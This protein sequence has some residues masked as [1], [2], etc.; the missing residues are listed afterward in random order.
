MN[1]QRHRA[2]S[3]ARR[4]LVLSSL[5]LLLPANLAFAS[6]LV[7]EGGETLS[8]QQLSSL[9]VQ[10][11][12]TDD[13]A[14]ITQT[15]VY[16]ATPSEQGA[17]E[18]T[19]HL[20][21]AAGTTVSA[22]RVSD[23]AQTFEVLDA[24][25]ADSL[26]RHL[27][28]GLRESGPMRGLGSEMLVVEPFQHEP[29]LGSP[30]ITL[31]LE[32]PLQ[33]RGTLQGVSL[34]VDWCHATVNDVSISV[35]AET[36]APLRALYGPYTSL[37]VTRDGLHRATASHWSYGLA[38][39]LPIELLL[40]SGEEPIR[41][42]LLPFRYSPD[43]DSGYVMALLTADSEPPAVD[44]VPRDIAVVLD[45]S[46]SMDGEKIQQGRAALNG[47]LDGLSPADRV[48]LF[49]FNGSVDSFRN[50]VTEADADTIAAGKAFVSDIIADGETN[51][52][53]AL[54]AAF[55]ALP[56][57]SGHPRYIVFITD[58]IPTAGETDVE[59]ILANARKHESKTRIFTFGVGLDVNTVLL[60]QLAADSGGDALY[61]WPGQSVATAVATFFD[62]I[63]APL[64][65]DPVLNLSAFGVTDLQPTVLQ[66][67][68]AGQTALVVGRY[69]TPGLGTF[70]LDGHDGTS[71]VSHVFEVTLPNHEVETGYVPRVWATRRIG[72]M[73]QTVKLGRGV[74]GVVE[75]AVRLADRWGIET[76][77]TSWTVDED[78]DTSMEYS[79]VPQD[80]SG[81][82]AVGTSSSIDSYTKE[83]GYNGAGALASVR[84]FRDRTLA[85]REGW[86]ADTSVPDGQEFHH[87]HF[88]SAAYFDLAEQ[89]ADAGIGGFF[90][91]GR[92]L[93]FELMGAHIA[94]TDAADAAHPDAAPETEGAVAAQETP[95]GATETALVWSGIETA[96]VPGH[97]TAGCSGSRGLPLGSLAGVLVLMALGV[98]RRR[99]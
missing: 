9:S 35:T 83:D 80:S 76:D 32:V 74:G 31:K 65:A 1:S 70:S 42:D 82:A 2:W 67:V 23:A 84:F 49:T 62:Q 14:T 29:H 94:V 55:N 39:E 5:A 78:G 96:P 43:P 22:V 13:G 36:T 53:A 33:Q 85:L 68:F 95:M 3:A 11:T 46:G 47:V 40:S 8:L 61:V 86:Y 89:L 73:L 69:T 64:L 56:G 75:E 57:G 37:T 99:R 19:F 20:D 6:G 88:G 15:R 4:G 10:A 28:T 63:Q 44:V 41:V 98:L 30:V 17:M 16:V 48:A 27:V 51:I 77:F 92:S 90:A 7:A 52:D 91:I 60:D 26:R 79:D 93:R 38:T 72:D 59:T 50:Q 71:S 21:L 18:M 81:S 97:K 34:P 87:V 58:G 12:L 54:D 45:R 24:D 25:A 66:D